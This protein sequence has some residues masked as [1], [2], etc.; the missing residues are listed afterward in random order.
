M[1]KTGTDFA[2]AQR[3]T[4]PQVKWRHKATTRLQ[5][6]NNAAN[7]QGRFSA[8]WFARLTALLIVIMKIMELFGTLVRFILLGTLFV[9]ALPLLFLAAKLSKVNS[10][11]ILNEKVSFRS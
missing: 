2:F 5:N 6:S 1:L 4:K 11:W 10:G 8:L 3:T 9:L 7:G